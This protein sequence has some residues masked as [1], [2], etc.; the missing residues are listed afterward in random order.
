MKNQITKFLL[1]L[2][3]LTL[4]TVAC[5]PFPAKPGGDPAVLRVMAYGFGSNATPSSGHSVTQETGTAGAFVVTDAFPD[6]SIRVHFSKPM[7]GSTIQGNSQYNPDGTTIRVD[8]LDPTSDPIPC[9]KATNVIL[10]ANFPANTPVCYDPASPTDGGALFIPGPVDA[11]GAVAWMKYGEVYTITG[12]VKDYEGKALTL[13]VSVST[14]QRPLPF[15]RSSDGYS[16]SLDWNDS[17]APG[18]EVLWS[19]TGVAGSYVH[20]WYFDNG[21]ICDGFF[22]SPWAYGGLYHT[23]LTPQTDYWYQVKETT[24]STATPPDVATATRPDVAGPITTVKPLLPTLG[25][26]TTPP[27]GPTIIPGVIKVS[28]PRVRGVTSYQIE[29]AADAATLS[30]SVIAT[31]AGTTAATQSYLAVGPAGTAT[32]GTLASGTKYWFRVT[33]VYGTTPA[34][35][36]GRAAGKVAP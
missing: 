15:P 24:G 21:D 17:G 35:V 3:A 10:S 27:P 31:Q 25:V 28:W 14:D 26:T 16:A 22:C 11:D 30:W 9:V 5:D 1:P 32:A 7:D 20:L 2:A 8:P 12:T 18:Y 36:V 34:A 4:V 13:N 33:P 23:Q 6:D 19:P 29:Q